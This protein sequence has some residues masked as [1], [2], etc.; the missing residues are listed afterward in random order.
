M[1]IRI[2]VPKTRSLAQIWN[3]Q[4]FFE[5]RKYDS[6]HVRE[7]DED[8]KFQVLPKESS[9]GLVG[10]VYESKS[11][12]F[13][14]QLNTNSEVKNYKLTGRQLDV[15]RYCKFGIAAPIFKK[16]TDKIIAVVTFDS[17]I[18]IEHPS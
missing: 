11:V 17:E 12:K 18:E 14:F 2:F 3:K 6:L 13:D 1:N 7:I 15:T 5:Y 8:L 16:D 9:Q 10:M 4:L